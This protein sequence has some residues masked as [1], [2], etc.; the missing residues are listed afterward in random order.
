[1]PDQNNQLMSLSLDQFKEILFIALDHELAYWKGAIVFDD[2]D[3]AVEGDKY[4]RR[5]VERFV[6]QQKTDKLEEMLKFYMERFKL[7]DEYGFPD[8]LYQKTGYKIEPI[9]GLKTS[10][11]M[12]RNLRVSISGKEKSALSFVSIELPAGSGSIYGIR[13]EHPEL[14]AEW[15]DQNTIEILIPKVREEIDKVYRVRTYG[16]VINIIYKEL[17]N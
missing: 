8:I 12:R 6:R 16:E 5:R 13:G 1:M 15:L 11:S 7:K 14:K 2:F 17:G 3:P 10:V 9:P 4:F